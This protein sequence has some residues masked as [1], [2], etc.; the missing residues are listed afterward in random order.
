MDREKN[1]IELLN[2][3]ISKY[4]Y[5]HKRHVYSKSYSLRGWSGRKGRLFINRLK[6]HQNY[7]LPIT[8]TI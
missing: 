1:N 6:Q 8:K 3:V 5:K 4:K 7:K 2:K